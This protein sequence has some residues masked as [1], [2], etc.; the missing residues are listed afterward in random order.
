VSAAVNRREAIPMS[1]S[2]P[3]CHSS[4]TGCRALRNGPEPDAVHGVLALARSSGSSCKPPPSWEDPR[5]DS[6]R[7]AH[8]AAYRA[9]ERS[10]LCRG[11]HCGAVGSSEAMSTSSTSGP[12]GRGW[13]SSVLLAAMR[14][15]RCPWQLA[16]AVRTG[17]SCFAL[18]DE[19]KC[20]GAGVGSE[21]SR[22]VPGSG[23]RGPY[24][25]RWREGRTAAVPRSRSTSC[26][27]TPAASDWR[28]ILTKTG[29][30]GRATL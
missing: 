25:Q 30:Y 14:Y 3:P 29:G 17:Q 13:G 11:Q 18:D 16:R 8:R 4:L 2:S 21:P 12:E 24:I 9:F 20:E 28:R 7:R 15:F 22:S 19:G 23:V 10:T 6:P 5:A 1:I 26:H 27:C